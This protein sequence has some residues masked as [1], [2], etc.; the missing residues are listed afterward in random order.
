MSDEAH[1]HADAPN[2]EDEQYL[3]VMN[4]EEQYSIWAVGRPIPPG[5]HASGTHGTRQE[6][7][8]HIGREWT[9]MRPKSLRLAMTDS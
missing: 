9:D 3:V 5:W 6:C 1:G 4:D 7:L 8:E 2:P